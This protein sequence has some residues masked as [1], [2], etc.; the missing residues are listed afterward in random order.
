M[1]KKTDQRDQ[2]L[3]AAKVSNDPTVKMALEKLLFTVSLAHDKEYIEWAD[4]SHFQ[5]GCT[6][7]VPSMSHD[8]TFSLT[9]N[10]TQI[11]VFSIEHQI[12]MFPYGHLYNVNDPLPGVILN[13]ELNI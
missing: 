9:W 12:V 3:E 4:K 7:T 13:P 8:T 5:S 6:I 10:D 1:S 2:L 11:Q